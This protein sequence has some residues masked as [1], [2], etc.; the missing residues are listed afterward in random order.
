MKTVH[1]FLGSSVRWEHEGPTHVR[2]HGS[3]ATEYLQVVTDDSSVADMCQAMREVTGFFAGVYLSER[4]LVAVVDRIRS[5]PL[6]F[7][8]RGN[9]IF[10]SDIADWVREQVGGTS[11]DPLSATEM[12]LT[13]YVTGPNTLYSQVKQLQAGEL[14]VVDLTSDAPDL[15]IH[16]YYRY[17]PGAVR[18]L[19]IGGFGD[20][21]DQVLSDLF[22]RLIRWASGRTLVVPLSGGL[23]SR[24][25]VTMLKRLGYP[26][27]ITFSYGK[28]GNSEAM[29]SQGI[30]ELLGFRW[31]FVPYDVESWSNWSRG[32]EKEDYYKFSNTLSAIS[33]IQDCPAVG[34]L[35]RRNAIPVDSIFVPGHSADLLAG[36]RSS[37]R[38]QIYSG[39]VLG[40]SNVVS[41][42]VDFH[43][44]LWDW[45]HVS[46]RLL[47]IFSSRVD[48]YVAS[49]PCD[50]VEGA[51]A[52][53]ESWDWAERQAKF[54]VN[55][56]RAYEFFGFDWW[57]PFWDKAF[58]DFWS[59]VP[60]AYRIN[61]SFY[62]EFVDNLFVQ[63]SG[64]SVTQPRQGYRDRMGAAFRSVLR[65][66]HIFPLYRLVRNQLNRFSVYDSDP[67]GW[68]GLVGR[69]HFRRL[70]T[71]RENINSFLV[72]DR[73]GI[74]SPK[75]AGLI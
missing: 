42:L 41:E 12:V 2:R 62:D 46:S 17:E 59:G 19:G 75:Q 61:K 58:V 52:A 29:V 36:S 25:I 40:A 6:F 28:P 10:I 30:A 47:P 72:L 7:G 70:Y 48:S 11:M 34:E 38:P 54:I 69:D 57:L 18:D 71:G 35:K 31:E 37:A 16:R 15:R 23:D 74:D 43:Y 27:V 32:Q 49:I 13:G 4:R 8:T 21:L 53:F 51:V 60:L 67:F 63:V 68:Y 3:N 39:R 56:V 66:P 1:L 22:T 14:L 20:L 44:S 33:H 24:L 64:H 65:A 73:M 50:T 26:H 5:I 45:R 9:Q 55:S